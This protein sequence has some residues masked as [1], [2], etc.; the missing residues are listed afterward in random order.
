[1]RYVRAQ[2]RRLELPGVDR[3]DLAQE[4]FLEFARA[5]L[6]ANLTHAMRVAVLAM[7]R[8]R[9]RQLRAGRSFQFSRRHEALGNP[10]ELPS[11][12]YPEPMVGTVELL[13]RLTDSEAQVLTLVCGLDG[14]PGRSHG[15]VGTILG[16]PRQYV[17]RWYH[18]ALGKLAASGG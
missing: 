13:G 14:S 6:P 4:A 17:W 11:R 9:R 5:G 18:S 3:D 16:L 15:E 8:H 7:R 10:D 1:M 12:S 2:A